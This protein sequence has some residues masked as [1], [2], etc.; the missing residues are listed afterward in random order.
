MAGHSS[1]R[2]RARIDLGTRPL[3]LLWVSRT[4]RANDARATGTWQLD[5]P[6]ELRRSLAA[7][8]LALRTRGVQSTI[9]RMVPFAECEAVGPASR[10]R[11]KT[12]GPDGCNLRH[13]TAQPGYARGGFSMFRFKAAAC[14]LALAA[15]TIGAR[16]P[17]ITPPAPF[18]SSPRRPAAATTISRA[19]SRRRSA[20]SLGPAGDRG[21]PSEPASSAASSRVR[22]RTATR[23]SWAAARCSSCRSRRQ[24]DY[25]VLTDFAPIS[26]L[27]RSPNVL[28]VQP[29]A[30][31]EHRA[32]AGR[33]RPTKPGALLYG[34]GCERQVAARGAA[35][36]S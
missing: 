22:R 20:R 12:N 15:A 19:S 29:V 28:V 18:A 31:G 7:L 6:V 21:Q 27:E 3:T 24:S 14:A 5:E 35:R 16:P 36:C 33:A 13:T 8:H 23:S 4:T 2:S 25:D 34:T 10:L 30:Q 26:Q 17:R 1:G 32:G 9:R 11:H